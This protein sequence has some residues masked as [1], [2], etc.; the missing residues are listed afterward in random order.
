[1]NLP[2]DASIPYI[3]PDHPLQ[4]S[5]T[6]LIVDD[7]PHSSDTTSPTGQTPFTQQHTQ[8]PSSPFPLATIDDQ[9]Q[10][11]QSQPYQMGQQP[12]DLG[13][14]ITPSNTLEAIPSKGQATGDRFIT[15]ASKYQTAPALPDWETAY[16]DQR[17][18]RWGSK[19]KEDLKGW[20]GGHGPVRSN[21]ARTTTDLPDTTYFGQPVTGTIGLH[22]PKEVVRI[23]RDWSGGEVC[24]FDTTFPIELEDRITPD[25]WR[26]FIDQ[27]N[28]HLAEAYSVKGAVMDNLLAIFTWWTS[29]LWSTSHFERGLK[30]AEKTIQQANTEVF[31]SKG[32]RVLSPRSVALQFLEIEYY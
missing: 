28:I 29:L 31:E 9:H 1:M 2:H 13:P 30:E 11:T 14:F 22:L 18:E 3:P 8:G 6:S 26:T 16:R 23:E 21:Y 5:P 10:I 15:P 7:T 32:L 27:L 25:Q 19:V 24:Q 12:T 17:R 20:R 4:P